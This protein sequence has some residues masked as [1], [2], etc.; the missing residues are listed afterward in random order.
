MRDQDAIVAIELHH[1]GDGAERDQIEQGSEIRFGFVGKQSTLAHFSA[2]CQQGIKHNADTGYG[3]ARKA[4]TGLVR[5]DDGGGVRQQVARQ[6]VIGDQRRNAESVG[7]GNT[8]VTGDAVVDGDDH[9]RLHLGRDHNDLGR[10]AIAGLEAI[11]YE[12][13]DF[14]AEAAQA[15]NADRAGGCAIAIVVGDDQQALACLNCVGQEHTRFGAAFQVVQ[16]QQIFQL[17]IRLFR[18]RDT[19]RRVKP[20]QQRGNAR[21]FER[22]HGAWRNLTTDKASHNDSSRRDL[23]QNL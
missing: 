9:V 5:V 17:R 18:R 16:R 3:F 23:R 1:I 8:R 14:R 22:P 15:A 13:V 19:T 12:V 7:L 2:Q 4:T 11:G 21:L 10:Q 6:M 20:R